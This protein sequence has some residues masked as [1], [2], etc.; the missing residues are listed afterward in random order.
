PR[1][2]SPSNPLLVPRQ[3]MEVLLDMDRGKSYFSVKQSAE[4]LDQKGLVAGVVYPR[5]ARRREQKEQKRRQVNESLGCPRPLC[6]PDG[7]GPSQRL[8][9][10]GR[11]TAA[12]ARDCRRSS[13]SSSGL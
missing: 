4:L 11:L 8:L 1:W 2:V 5:D 10:H 9:A 7:G 3:R 13:E 12:D 6:R